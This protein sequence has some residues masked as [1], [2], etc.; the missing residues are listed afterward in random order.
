MTTFDGVNPIDLEES[1]PV[2]RLRLGWALVLFYF[3][4][5]HIGQQLPKV[6]P[7]FA[8]GLGVA[9]LVSAMTAIRDARLRI[10]DERSRTRRAGL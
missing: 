4:E 1:W 7:L 10:R 5:V 2:Q 3:F 8:L 9:C 6:L